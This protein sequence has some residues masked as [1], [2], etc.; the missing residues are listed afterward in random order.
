MATK[1]RAVE[2]I[3]LMAV[4][5]CG[6]YWLRPQ[7]SGNPREVDGAN[8]TLLF[9][10]DENSEWCVKARPLIEEFAID[11]GL[12]LVPMTA[13]PDNPELRKY[14]SLLNRAH[15]QIPFVVILDLEGKPLHYWVGFLTR[16]EME[17]R[18][19][20]PPMR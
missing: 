14:K 7:L 12:K 20:A 13:H 2:L 4:I 11:K 17:E 10:Q 9:F 1:S 3:L 15:G 8:G 19:A 18:C 6:A 5:A 16:E